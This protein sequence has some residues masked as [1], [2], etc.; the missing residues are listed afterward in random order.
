[1]WHWAAA[2][3]PRAGPSDPALES[4]SHCPSR[5]ELA[6]QQQSSLLPYSEKRLAS[7][8]AEGGAPSSE[9]WQ[10]LCYVT[11]VT[12]S[13]ARRETVAKGEAER[14]RQNRGDRSHKTAEKLGAEGALTLRGLR[15]DTAPRKP[16]LKEARSGQKRS[17][18]STFASTSH[19]P[20][21][22]QSQSRFGQM[23]FPNSSLWKLTLARLIV[24]KLVCTQAG[25]QAIRLSAGLPWPEQQSMASQPLLTQQTPGGCHSNYGTTGTLIPREHF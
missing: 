19:S 16:H 23:F 5:E 25:A 22:V 12:P 13:H 2:E 6:E 10:R 1:M 21:D 7:A 18:T 20:A 14:A 24:L 9:P 11:R 3:V 8:A 4:G 15:K 17:P